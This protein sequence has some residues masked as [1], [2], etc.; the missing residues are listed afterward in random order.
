MAG[1]IG[2]FVLIYIGGC[3]V[4]GVVLALGVWLT[5]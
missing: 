5:E 2:N 1:L 3:V 4:V